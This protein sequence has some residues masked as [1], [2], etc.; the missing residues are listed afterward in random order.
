[1]KRVHEFVCI[2]CPLSCE[3][4]LIEEGGKILEISGD[5]CKKGKGYVVAE[6]TN[7]LRIMTTTVRIE[8]GILPVLPVRS[9]GFIPKV[10]MKKCVKELAK[11]KIKA[12]I[13]CEEVICTNI[14]NT[15]INI[16]SSRDMV[17]RKDLVR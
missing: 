16:V 3:I 6:F 15:G 17:K 5:R 11:V 14:L 4:E 13:K 12:P 2:E 8:D 10:L 1:M 7:P 9:E